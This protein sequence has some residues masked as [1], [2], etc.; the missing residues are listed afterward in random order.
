MP[1]CPYLPYALAFILAF[2][3]AKMLAGP[4]LGAHVPVG[5]ALV[6]IVASLVGAVVASL[7]CK[8]RASLLPR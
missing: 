2:I 7:V 1:L 3:G 6:V 5:A 4:L 8:K